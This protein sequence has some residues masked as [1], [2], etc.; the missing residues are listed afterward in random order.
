MIAS[1][2]QTLP[3]EPDTPLIEE[4]K[5]SGFRIQGLAVFYR[6]KGFWC[7]VWGFSLGFGIQGLGLVADSPQSQV[8]K[9]A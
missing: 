7:R 4:C 9:R 6:A 8:V 2:A 5:L 1:G 3:R